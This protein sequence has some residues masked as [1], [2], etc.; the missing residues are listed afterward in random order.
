MKAIYWYC[1]LAVIGAV[2]TVFIMFRK[3][4]YYELLTFFLSAMMTAFTGEMIVLLIFNSYSYYPGVFKDY[5]AEDIFGH[6]IPNA[7]L[8]PATALLVAACSLRCRW[9]ALITAIYTL[10]DVLYVRLGIYGHNWWR[11]WM[12]SIAIFSYCVLM[13]AW[14]TQLKNRRHTLLKF[15]TFWLALLVIMKLPVSILLL[16]GMQHTYVGW[17]EDSYRDSGIFSVIYNGAVSLC[18]SIFI[19]VLKGWCWKFA[20]LS[21]ISHAMASYCAAA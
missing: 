7:T 4:N 15:I 18:C 16:A 11:T 5:Y 10:L 17:F 21:S 1:A 19:C 3:K 20:A 6:I 2:L 12:T 9:I 13:K 14:Y 8:W